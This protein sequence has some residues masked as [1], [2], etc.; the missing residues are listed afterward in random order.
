MAKKTVQDVN[1]EGKKVFVRVDFNVPLDGATITDDTRIRAA[2]PTLEA[3]SGSGLVLASHLGRPKGKRVPEESLAPCAERLSELLGKPVTFVDDCIGEARNAAVAN[4]KPGEVVLLENTRFYK[5]EESKDKDEMMAFAK[6]LAA[7]VDAYVNDAFG[8]SHRKHASVYGVPSIVKPAVMGLLVQA[9]V[10]ALSAVY[11]AQPDGFVVILGGAKVDEKINVILSLLP[12]CGKMLIGGAMAWAFFKAKGM[13]IGMSYCPEGSPEAAEKVLSE[14]GDH[15]DKLVLPVD[16]H[17]KN[18]QGDH[19][20]LFAPADGIKPGWDALDIGPETRA[21]FSGLIKGAK[22]I[23]WNGPMGK[24]EDKPFD[25]GTLAVA[26]A[27][28]D[29][30]GYCVVGGGDSVAAV[31]QMGLADKMEH[32]S[33]GGG[34]SLEYMENGGLPGIDALEDK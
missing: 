13:E 10:E 9:E 23:F 16:V 11:N 21:L 3:L 28:A 2:L 6:D 24:F 29:C 12:R 8:S 18:E 4:L 26:Q 25:E 14:M 34:A 1:L 20:M 31:T 5:G 17:M 7:G 30:P 32:V 27:V 22:V 19:S 33:T 15:L